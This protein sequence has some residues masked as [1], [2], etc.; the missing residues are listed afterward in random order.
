[1][2]ISDARKRE[3]LIVGLTVEHE[4]GTMIHSDNTIARKS[5]IHFN[6]KKTL[7]RFWMLLDKEQRM[8]ADNTL[9]VGL[10]RTTLNITLKEYIPVDEYLEILEGE[11]E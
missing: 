6:D 5:I 4:W 10:N 2:S 8:K 7:L 3:E 9:Y 1:M 11:E